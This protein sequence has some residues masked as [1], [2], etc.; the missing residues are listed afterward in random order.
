M[1]KT[2]IPKATHT[3]G[4][5]KTWKSKVRHRSIDGRTI[6]RKGT[7]VIAHVTPVQCAPLSAEVIANARLIAAAP[8]ML[9]ACKSMLEA[10]ACCQPEEGII[11]IQ[12][13]LAKATGENA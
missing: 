9:E 12:A 6:I 8:E 1:C 13:A 7:S 3:P 2:P 11:R 4:P 5:W 10:W